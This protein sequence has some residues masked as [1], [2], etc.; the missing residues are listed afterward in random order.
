MLSHAGSG[1]LVGEQP[2]S[3][4]PWLS[5]VLLLWL[6]PCSSPAAALGFAEGLWL[7]AGSHHSPIFAVCA[8]VPSIRVLR[9]RF[10]QR[11]IKLSSQV[12]IPFAFN[13]FDLSLPLLEP[14][15]NEAAFF[16]SNKF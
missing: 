14:D 9:W 13:L 3:A 5:H 11:W 4:K 16:V 8:Q 6:K 2:A 10:M 7:L 1:K 12:F 15:A